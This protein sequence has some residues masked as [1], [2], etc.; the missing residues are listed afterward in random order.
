MVSNRR[1]FMTKAFIPLVGILGGGAALNIVQPSQTI[2]V[3]AVNVDITTSIGNSVT[4][5]GDE[6]LLKLEQ[7]ITIN[8]LK[9]SVILE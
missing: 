6:L 5:F 4:L 9:H 1:K 8:T 7:L 3:T 2:R